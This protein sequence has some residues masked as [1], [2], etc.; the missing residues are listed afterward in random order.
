MYGN[1]V[2]DVRFGLYALLK[3]LIE[4]CNA[5]VAS[6]IFPMISMQ[7]AFESEV[8][9]PEAFRSWASLTD[10]SQSARYMTQYSTADTLRYGQWLKAY[11]ES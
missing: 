4:C 7:T 9:Y 11:R 8:A 3:L 6:H 1:H 10:R 5:K 2:P